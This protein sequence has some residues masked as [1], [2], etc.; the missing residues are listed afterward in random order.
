MT[1]PPVPHLAALALGAIGAMA[2]YRLVMR[3]K[4]R[5]TEELDL[6]RAQSVNDQAQRRTLKRDPET[7]IYRP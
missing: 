1:I 2:L 4:R 3:E 6:L 7:G 5:V